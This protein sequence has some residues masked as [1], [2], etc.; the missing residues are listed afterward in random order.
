MLFPGGI[1]QGC[2]D[3]K[4]GRDGDKVVLTS[5]TPKALEQGVGF[6]QAELTFVCKKPGSSSWKNARAGPQRHIH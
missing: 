4:S 6:K 5:P 1:P 2:D 3:P